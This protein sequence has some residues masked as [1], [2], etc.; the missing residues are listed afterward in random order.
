MLKRRISR[1]EFMEIALAAENADRRLQ[2][3]DGEIVEVVS[4]NKTSELAGN[5]IISLGGFVKPRKLGRITVPDGG[6]SI[7]G[8]QYIPDC[9]FV[10][11]KRQP[12]TS[13]EAYPNIAPD[14]VVEVL[15][16]GNLRTAEERDKITRKVVNYLSVGC[17]VW[18]LYPDEEKLE[19]YIPGEAVR[20][21]RN[22][23]M[24]KGRGALEGFELEISK[25]W[26]WGKTITLKRLKAD[27]IIQLIVS[28]D[29]HHARSIVRNEASVKEM[30]LALEKTDSAM[31]RWCI[32]AVL[33]ERQAKTAIPILIRHLNDSNFTVRCYSAESL[34]KICDP[35]AIPL[36]IEALSSEVDNLRGCAAW[37]LGELL[38]QESEEAL[39]K[40]LP[41]ET[42]QWSKNHMK[43]ALARIADIQKTS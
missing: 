41:I 4:S 40:A 10:S 6:Y 24:L 27:E 1:D 11:Y 28:P 32:C 31:V 18:L 26:R 38:A 19:R 13:D 29:A 14:L 2:L 42:N 12:H 36:L 25:I 7:A 39:R 5:M 23:E 20:T 43:E 9:A 35:K 16:P 21:Y 17:E 22:G 15:S 3:I 8:E 30:I 34:G 33:G 37:S